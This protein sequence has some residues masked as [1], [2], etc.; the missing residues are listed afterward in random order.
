MIER[1]DHNKHFVNIATW[2]YQWGL[3]IPQQEYMPECGWVIDD[4]MAAFIVQTDTLYCF[5]EYLISDPKTNKRKR[6]EM[7]KKLLDFMV[8]E[9]KNLGYKKIIVTATHPG[10]L[11]ILDENEF[12]E[13][14][15]CFLMRDI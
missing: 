7:S 6:K 1:F 3:K 8:I 14:P 13:K 11:S 4:K 2:Y 10:T 5:L 12:I 15:T 9:A